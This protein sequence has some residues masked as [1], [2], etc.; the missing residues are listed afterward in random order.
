[1]KILGLIGGT[2]WYSTEAYYRLINE[3]VAERLGAQTNPEMI[4][5]SI[6]IDIMR[7]QDWDVI[8]RKYLEVAQKLENAGAEGILICANTP[9]KVYDYVQPRIT[10]PIL[11]I[12][13]ATGKEAQKRSMK[14]LG[15]LGNKPTMTGGY[16]PEILEKEFGLQ[17]LIPEHEA[18]IDKSHYFVGKELTQ[19]KFTDKARSFY[20]EQIERLRERGADGIILGCTEL[21]LLIDNEQSSLPLLPTTELHAEMAVDFILE[22][23]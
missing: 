12:A 1:M 11:H 2:S 16:I 3:K 5:Y 15:L 4:L 21:P 19:G 8:N 22:E 20:S 10:I 14:T 7:E 9:H 6:R 13:R 18:T 23:N 17:T